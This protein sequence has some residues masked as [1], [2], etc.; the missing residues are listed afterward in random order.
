MKRALL[1]AAV[2]AV[3]LFAGCGGP[4]PTPSPGTEPEP[5]PGSS[6]QASDMDWNTDPD[7]FSDP[8]AASSSSALVDQDDEGQPL[9]GTTVEAYAPL[10]Q[11]CDLTSGLRGS[12]LPTGCSNNGPLRSSPLAWVRLDGVTMENGTPVSS[13]AVDG[14]LLTGLVNGTAVSG[15]DFEKAYFAGVA[16]SGATVQLR[17]EHVERPTARQADVWHYE[18]RYLT[19]N[20]EWK[21][22]CQGKKA[23]VTAG[24]WDFHQGVAG[25][26]AKIA[27]SAVLTIGCERSAIEK[28]INGGY[29][30]WVTRSGVSLDPYHQACVR[31]LRADYCGDGVS[32][33]KPGAKVNLY[34]PLG[35]QQDDEKWVLEAQWTAT[36]AQCLNT[37]NL[38]PLNAPCLATLGTPTCGQATS[39]T[40]DTLIISETPHTGGRD[41]YLNQ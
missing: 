6:S 38:A 10:L 27:D 34:D 9:N 28:C 8:V 3:T 31:M 32:H 37:L 35:I 16:T 39:L 11:G 4:A 14:T 30:P 13:V 33:T 24:R 36:G 18:F 1:I 26:G 20:G 7:V 15:Q 40:G 12:A 2:S 41:G 19:A 22:L 23:V 21:N 17:V 25:D 29:R 5:A